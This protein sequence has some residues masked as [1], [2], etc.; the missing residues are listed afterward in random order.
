MICRFA[1]WVLIYGMAT[2]DLIIISFTIKRVIKS[3]FK[4]HS[5]YIVGR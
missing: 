2:E 3:A 4:K 1:N 5:I